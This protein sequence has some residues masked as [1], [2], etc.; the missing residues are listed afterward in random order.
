MSEELKAYAEQ[1][2]KVVRMKENG[3]LTHVT[4]NLQ[5][6]NKQ[7]KSRWLAAGLIAHRY[8]EQLGEAQQHQ[9]IFLLKSLPSWDAALFVRQVGTV[10]LR[11]LMPLMGMDMS[12]ALRHFSSGT[13]LELCFMSPQGNEVRLEI[14]WEAAFAKAASQRMR[15]SIPDFV[16]ALT[17]LVEFTHLTA[18]VEIQQP[19]ARTFKAP[20]ENILVVTV[21]PAEL[22]DTIN[23]LSGNV[24][25]ITK[26]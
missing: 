22:H 5:E 1:L 21:L 4:L 19:G 6:L 14:C 15:R 13:P 9:D 8:V 18:M 2:R 25:H 7:K 3:Q 24:T 16:D 23:L 26:H 12:L 11:L 17:G 20:D 10:Q